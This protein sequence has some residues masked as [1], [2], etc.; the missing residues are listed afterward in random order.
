M[1]NAIVQNKKGETAVIALPSD[2][3]SIWKVFYVR[4]YPEY[5]SAS[6]KKTVFRCVRRHCEI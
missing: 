6:D 5:H 3:F 4:L 2:R 1:I